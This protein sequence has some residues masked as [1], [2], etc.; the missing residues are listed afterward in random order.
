MSKEND[1]TNINLRVTHKE[2]EAIRKAATHRGLSMSD[3]L[4][5]LVRKDNPKN[6]PRGSKTS[7][8]DNE[9]YEGEVVNE[10]T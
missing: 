7:L 6:W 3:Y 1:G 2:K 4:R 10:A 5:A 8:M 9:V